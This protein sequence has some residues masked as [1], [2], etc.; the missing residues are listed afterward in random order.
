METSLVIVL[1][2]VA[3]GNNIWILYE[4]TS[5]GKVKKN[6]ISRDKV[7]LQYYYKTWN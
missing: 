4:V 5:S 7:K 6:Q 2:I 3:F 1:A